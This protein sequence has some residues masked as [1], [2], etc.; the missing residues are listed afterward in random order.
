MNKINHLEHK[1]TSSSE[2]HKLA[3]AHG[4]FFF[5]L[6]FV[7]PELRFGSC[8]F[9]G[10][11]QVIARTQQIWIK[12]QES[13]RLLDKLHENPPNLGSRILGFGGGGGCQLPHHNI[14]VFDE[15]LIWLRAVIRIT[16]KVV[17][18][19]C[20]IRHVDLPSI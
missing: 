2:L 6:L 14:S 3:M 5:F 12:L 13:S 11:L 10:V 9:D 17:I 19:Y 15:V 20:R 1:L 7:H 8:H 4:I 18:L 16:A